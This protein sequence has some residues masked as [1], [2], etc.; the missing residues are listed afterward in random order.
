LALNAL[1]NDPKLSN[2]AAARIY[3]VNKDTLRDRRDGRPARRDI[4]ANSRKLTDLEEQTIVLYIIE[5]CARAFHPRLAYV[6]D[7]ANRLL[8][9]RDAPLLAYDG[10]TTLSNANE[11]FVRV[12]RV[13]TTTKGPDAK[14]QRPF[15]SGLHSYETPRPNT[16]SSTKIRIIST[17]PAL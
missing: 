14:I 2:R 1:R 5:L 3:D 9:E 13:N 8:R 17:R 4:P 15:A 6:E 12:L 11:S 16:A 10:L 7:M